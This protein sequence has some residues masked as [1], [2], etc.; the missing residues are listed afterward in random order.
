MRTRITRKIDRSFK[1]NVRTTPPPFPT[2][3]SSPVFRFLLSQI[4]LFHLAIPFIGN[5]LKL[6]RINLSLKI[7]KAEKNVYTCANAHNTIQR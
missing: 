7:I 4:Y 5:K 2:T 1:A 3:I 6:E